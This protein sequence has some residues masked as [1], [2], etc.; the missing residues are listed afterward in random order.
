MRDVL[1]H[2]AGLTNPDAKDTRGMTLEQLANHLGESGLKFEPGAKWEY[3]SGLTVAGRLVEIVS[4][5]GFA[6]YLKEHIF[7]PLGMTDTG[8]TLTVEQAARLATSYK[9]GKEPGDVGSRRNPRPDGA[10]HRRDRPAACSRR[11][12]TRPGFIRRF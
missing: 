7:Q 3:S 8:F 9:P 11:L 2:T 4:K 6:D 10:A 5:Q 1:T 12:A